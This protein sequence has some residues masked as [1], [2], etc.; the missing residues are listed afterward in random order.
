[1]GDRAGPRR[2]GFVR[3]R[4]PAVN[5][6]QTYTITFRGDLAEARKAWEEIRQILEAGGESLE[7]T[8][9]REQTRPF[10]EWTKP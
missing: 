8:D 4:A 10:G 3:E 1:M 7:I 5:G 2:V 9:L 6:V